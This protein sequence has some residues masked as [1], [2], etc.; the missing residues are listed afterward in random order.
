MTKAITLVVIL[1]LIA[2]FPFKLI[3]D[4]SVKW[5]TKP[6]V[7]TD[8]SPVEYIKIYAEKFGVDPNL[9]YSVGMCES[10]LSTKYPIGDN[11]HSFGMFAYFKSTW[12][13]YN[14][15]YNAR[16][17]LLEDLDIT[18]Y[19]DQIKLTAFVFSLGET[20]RKEWT[21]YVAISKGG[22]Y[23]FYSKFHKKDFTVS[24][25]YDTFIK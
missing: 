15:L 16:T 3:A 14:T 20:S 11:G 23:S 17:G 18:S 8:L 22:T 10:G 12:E 7:P 25:K 24:C 9:L 4:D 6:I 2:L 1:G 21:T 19:H 5:D 13:R